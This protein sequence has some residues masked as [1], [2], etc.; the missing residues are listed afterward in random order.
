LQHCIITVF[1]FKNHSKSSQQSSNLTR[2][3]YKQ[4]Q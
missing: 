2:S 3:Y 4:S 1:W